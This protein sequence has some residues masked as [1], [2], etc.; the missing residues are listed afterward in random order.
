MTHGPMEQNGK[1]RINALHIWSL[2]F[3]KGARNIHCKEDSLSTNGAW[4]T[5][6][7]HAEK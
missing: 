2:I 3:D 6:Y 4:E 1:P 5:G 7:K